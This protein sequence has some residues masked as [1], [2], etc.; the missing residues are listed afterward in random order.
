M[1]ISVTSNDDSVYRDMLK[2]NGHGDHMANMVDMVPKVIYS[3]VAYIPEQ[4]CVRDKNI[5]ITGHD[6]SVY[7]EMLKTNGHGDHIAN[8]VHMVPASLFLSYFIRPRTVMC[9]GYVYLCH[10]PFR[11]CVSRDVETK[12]SW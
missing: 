4:L 9:L 12:W 1:Y 11:L 5:F 6:G 8:M 7:P 2:T 3:V 10:K